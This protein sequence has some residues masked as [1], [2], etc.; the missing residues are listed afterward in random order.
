MSRIV[1]EQKRIKDS[2]EF[3]N[4]IMDLMEVSDLDTATN[5]GIFEQIKF[6]MLNGIINEDTEESSS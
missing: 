1:E 6:E 2:N 5:I 3:Y 4:L